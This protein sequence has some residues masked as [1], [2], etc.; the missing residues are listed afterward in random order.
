[1][2]ICSIC[3]EEKTLDFFYKEQNYYRPRCKQCYL[4]YR[5]QYRESELE[6]LREVSRRNY[7]VNKEKIKE[8]GKQYREK[9]KEKIAKNAKEYAKNNK[10]RIKQYKND[11]RD[12]LNEYNKN[13]ILKRLKYDPIFKFVTNLRS[14][15]RQS[16]KR[17]GNQYQKKSKTEHILG[18]TIEYFKEYISLKFTKGMSIDNHGKWHLDHIIPLATAKTE[19]EIIRLNHYTNF[20]PLWAKDNLSK[21]D[22]II[23]QQLILL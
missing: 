2:K 10:T 18:C 20:Q 14:L 1:M 12:K 15:I 4:L 11:N 6:R 23:E 5:K 9:N 16:F 17:N 13:Y 3:K 7:Q 22:K 19:E 21:S 8:R